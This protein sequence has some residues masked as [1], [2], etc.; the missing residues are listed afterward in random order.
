[1]LVFYSLFWGLEMHTYLRYSFLFS[2]LKGFTL[3]DA[4]GLAVMGNVDVHSV[5]ATSL[6]TSHRSF[7]PER[8]LEMS[9]KWKARPLPEH[10]IRLFV[11]ILSATNHFAE[12]MAIRK[13]W[14]QSS[15][16]KSSDVVVRFFVALVRLWHSFWC[17]ISCHDCHYR[18]DTIPSVVKHYRDG[19]LPFC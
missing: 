15:P 4:T 9:D 19:K 5:Y 7:S 17:S 10:P 1:M 11:G 14:M 16:I 2:H 3:E 12:R 18:L 8:V 13:T 6:P